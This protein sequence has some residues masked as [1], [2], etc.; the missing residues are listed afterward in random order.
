LSLLDKA[1]ADIIAGRFDQAATILQSCI[2]ANPLEATAWFYKGHLFFLQNRIPD[3]V[4]C[5]R[6]SLSLQ[7]EYPDVYADLGAS[8]ILDQRPREA[9]ALL[10]EGMRRFPEHSRSALNLAKLLSQ[11]GRYAEAEAHYHSVLNLAPDLFEAT[12][13]LSAMLID[14]GRPAKAR[15]I[16]ELFLRNHADHVPALS[17]LLLALDSEGKLEEALTVTQRIMEIVP[18]RNLNMVLAS[19]V[20]LVGRLG[21]LDLRGHA[22]ELVK[23]AIPIT[24]PDDNRALWLGADASALK[25]FAYLLPYYGMN[26]RDLLKV[27]RALAENIAARCPPRRYATPATSDR[28][29]IGFI[30]YNFGNHPIGH[31]L[32]VFFEAH[33]HAQ[34]EL[35][36][37]SLKPNTDDVS[38]YRAR[39]RKAADHFRD[40]R[41]KTDPELEAFIRADNLHILIDLDGYLHGGRPEILSRRPACIQIHWL[42]SLAGMPAPF[43]DYTIVDKVIVPDE[44]RYQGNGALI[45]LADAFQCGEKFHILTT[46]PKRESELLPENK[47]V[48]CAFGNWLKIDEDVFSCWMEILRNVP[49]SVLWLSTGPTKESINKMRNKA[50]AQGVDPDRL[51]MAQRAEPKI[52]H[53]QRH[54]LADLFLD[55]FTF[56]AATT[57]TDALSAGL[58]VL[59]KTGHTAQSR[60]SESLIRSTGIHE[61]ITPNKEE[62]VKTAIRLAKNPNE[63]DRLRIALTKAIHTAPLFDAHRMVR[64]F[65]LIYPAVWALYVRGKK[66]QHIDIDM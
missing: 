13:N 24:L 33:G 5:F 57:A 46:L 29:R 32:S 47:F 44:E 66:P 62:Y 54:Q 40:C 28:L 64:Q 20:S 53:I 21:R 27:H 19:Y 22:F 6:T 63:L 8:L 49:D 31:L 41:A 10:R 56:S 37:Y 2:Q 39:I 23:N 48:F 35:F 14:L 52:A 30:S 43:I 7:S 26:D 16:L 61:I 59:T 50:A 1:K 38:G 17:L 18:P 34:T 45:R 9:E 60:L 36:L 11:E 42:Q 4:D 12:Q 3:A 58:P 55:T 25:R 51:I 65:E 15:E